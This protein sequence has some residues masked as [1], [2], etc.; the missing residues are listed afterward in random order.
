MSLFWMVRK[1]TAS[2]VEDM[3]PPP[4][5]ELVCLLLRPLSDQDLCVECRPE[6]ENILSPVTYFHR[7]LPNL[8]KV[9]PLQSIVMTLI[10][11]FRVQII[12]MI[13]LLQTEK[14]FVQSFSFLNL[15]SF[16]QTCPRVAP[17]LF[18]SLGSLGLSSWWC[19]PTFTGPTGTSC[20]D[21]I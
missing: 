19:R 11:G 6:N 5:F 17:M 7:F 21:M 4:R 8:N 16:A 18:S 13:H 12:Q 10:N 2:K 9:G 15:H 3:A 1:S 20:K 14:L